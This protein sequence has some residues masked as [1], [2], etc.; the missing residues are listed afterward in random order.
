LTV[1]RLGGRAR[2]MAP[3]E[4]RT[5]SRDSPTALSGRPTMVNAGSPELICTWTSTSLTSMPLNAT[6]RIRATPRAEKLSVVMPGRC[7]SS[8]AK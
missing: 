2:P 5:R 3:S 7:A 6:V 1:I 8:M 4:L